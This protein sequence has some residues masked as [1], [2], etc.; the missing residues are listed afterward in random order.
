MKI[1][2]KLTLLFVGIG[3]LSVSIIGWI[4]YIKGKESLEQESFNRLT[5]VRE[6]KANQIEDY[7]EL[8]EN[9]IISYSKDFTVVN[10]MQRFKQDFSELPFEFK[11]SN[12]SV[13]FKFEDLEAYYE[14]EFIPRLNA[15]DQV[16]HV[17]EDFLIK[18]ESGRILQQIYISQNANPVGQ[19]QNLTN[20]NSPFSYCETHSIYHP[21]FK[22]FLDKFGYYDIFLVDNLS[23]DIVYSVYKEIDFGANLYEGSFANS[24]F[25][26]VFEAAKGSHESDF[27]TLVDYQP[28]KGSY[29]APAAFVA[30]PI[31]A[32]DSC[33]GVLVFQM[34]IEKINN[35]MT[36]NLEWKKV[37]LGESGE[38]Y[39]VSEDYTLRNQSRFLI[40]NRQ[41]Y[42]KMIEETG[43]DASVVEKIKTFNSSIGLQQVKT[44]GTI[45]ALNGDIDTRIFPDYRGVE[46]LSAYRPLN[47]R[48]LNW[49]IMSEIDKEEAFLPVYKLRNSI[50]IFLCATTLFIL[51]LSYFAS[52]MITRPIKSLTKTSR[53]LARG[54]WDVEVK[55]EQKDEIGVL[56][57]SFKSMQKSLHKLINDLKMI[58]HN[59][60]D[61]ISERTKELRRQKDMI[62]EKNKEVMASIRYA[63]RLQTAILPTPQFI[64]NNL[65]DS[66]VLFRPKDIVSGDF[67]W[68]TK[69]DNKVL[70]AAVDCTGHGVPG[71]LVSIVG[72]NGLNR[73]VKEFDL[74]KPS[75]IL[76][77]L[78]EIII[79]TFN[80]GEEKVK[81]GM[82]ISLLSI[83]TQTYEI[84]YAGANN[85]LWIARLDSKEM[86]VITPDKQ[87][88]G[89]FDFAQPFTNHSFQLKRGDCLFLFTDGYADQ[90]G[91]DNGKKLKYKPF[92][93]LLFKNM[94][95]PM[96][97]QKMILNQSFTK[98]MSDFEQ[99]DDVCVIGI[100][101]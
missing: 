10:A 24:N 62:A 8:I 88:I 52:K 29:N 84:E 64:Q 51:I 47:I 26:Q 11:K 1:G 61:T 57:L 70:I 38:T 6:M 99:V 23:G 41:E 36:N 13:N 43:T 93:D 46:V 67:Y 2:I 79:E 34:P 50:W 27:V 97:E 12:D 91:G 31:F 71:A 65:R 3:V 22:D 56:A 7:F 60:E 100:R 17:T 14:K 4:S 53:E 96:H 42:F 37:G 63:Q 40:E 25:T 30:S 32:G 59:L 92:Q 90:F 75:S 73:C 33:I 5:A 87:P 19:K 20:V 66:F 82:D 81:D 9:Q 76:N 21:L 55:V 58:N 98:W 44:E 39:L 18:S 49:V 89:N 48:G 54:N 74:T 16:K 28:Y 101:I 94:N 68:M 78:R 72:A 69:V 35:I 85:P 86:E 15:N 95:L 45:A 77:Q 80:A 83:D